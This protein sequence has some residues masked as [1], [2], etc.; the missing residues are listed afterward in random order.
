MVANSFI[1]RYKIHIMKDCRMTKLSTFDQLKVLLFNK[2]EYL[3]I[4][5]ELLKKVSGKSATFFLFCSWQGRVRWTKRPSFRPAGAKSGT[6]FR[7]TLW[8][9][10]VWRRTPLLCSSNVSRLCF[11][12]TRPSVLPSS[13]LTPKL[14]W[15]NRSRAACTDSLVPSSS[16]WWRTSRRVLRAAWASCILKVFHKRNAPASSWTTPTSRVT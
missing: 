2:S 5:P 11:S 10:A 13:F 9:I 6:T 7:W 16:I 15:M 8:K 14:S 4:F 3:Y 1:H 12:S